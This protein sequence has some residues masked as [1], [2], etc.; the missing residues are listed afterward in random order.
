[1]ALEQKLDH[2]LYMFFQM[3]DSY[4]K[5]FFYDLT[6]TEAKKRDAYFVL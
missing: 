3:P 6:N 4:V 1:M 5:C 2:G